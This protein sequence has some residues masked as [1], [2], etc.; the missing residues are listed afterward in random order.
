[1]LV[2]DRITQLIQKE[3]R[4]CDVSLF[5]SSGP[6]DSNGTFAHALHDEAKVRGFGG[7]ISFEQGEYVN[8]GGEGIPA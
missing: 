5:V 8:C 7:T 6:R 4:P 3:I 1:M 2:L